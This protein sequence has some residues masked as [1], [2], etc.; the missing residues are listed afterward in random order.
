MKKKGNKEGITTVAHKT[1]PSKHALEYSAGLIIR[2]I[3]IK[4]KKIQST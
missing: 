1:I 2:A 4:D 3:E